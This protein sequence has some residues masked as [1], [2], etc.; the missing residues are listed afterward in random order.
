ME[1]RSGWV[2]QGYWSSPSD[3]L[4]DEGPVEEALWGLCCSS[5][6]VC[7]S[8]GWDRRVLVVISR[9]RMQ[10]LGEREKAATSSGGDGSRKWIAARGDGRLDRAVEAGR[11]A[12]IHQYNIHMLDVDSVCILPVWA[13]W[14]GREC[15]LRVPRS[16]GRSSW[17][18]PSHVVMAEEAGERLLERA[19]RSS[20]G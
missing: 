3:S 9:R 2:P 13:T 11:G 1:S 20:A 10:G 12:G 18:G 19:A 17:T 5:R 8:G 4:Y 15:R 16:W 6:S 14:A 7:C